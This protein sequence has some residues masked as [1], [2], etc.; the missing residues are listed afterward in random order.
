MKTLLVSWAFLMAC[1]LPLAAQGD[2][3]SRTGFI[4]AGTLT[5]R[6]YGTDGFRFQAPSLSFG[7]RSFSRNRVTTT[8]YEFSAGMATGQMTDLHSFAVFIR[9]VD[10]MIGYSVDAGPALL[11]FGPFFTLDYRVVCFPESTGINYGM[12]TG[13]RA[14]VQAG[15][16]LDIGHSV[17]DFRLRE[18]LAGVLC[19]NELYR[20][21]FYYW[22]N[23]AEL[24]RDLHRNG[25]SFSSDRFHHA[26]FEVRL[27]LHPDSRVAFAWC[28]DYSRYGRDDAME[29]FQQSFRLYIRPSVK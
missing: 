9:P 11:T 5:V 22:R 28:A 17:V 27:R 1:I 3:S 13:L 21:Q 4:G 25:R 10:L 19:T 23:P 29:T 14:G 6:Q 24:L 16:R 12:M 7:T 18:S 26:S 8:E 20:D 2:S 15:M